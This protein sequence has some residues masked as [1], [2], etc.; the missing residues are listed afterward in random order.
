MVQRSIPKGMKYPITQLN[1]I[2]QKNSFSCGKESL[3][4]YIQKQASQDVAKGLSVCYIL[5]DEFNLIIGYYTLSTLS[6][7]RE[8]I[9]EDIK[10]KIPGSYNAPAILIGRLA[11]N[12]SHHRQGIG[13]L[14][15]FDA[16]KRSFESS[17]KIGSMAVAVDPIDEEA[18]KFYARYGFILLPKSGKMFLSM[19][20]IYK[21]LSQAGYIES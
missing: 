15:L 19:K 11:V 9:P 13:E 6:I 17:L 12:K 4:H 2:H 7:S 1:S 16:L 18:I 8:E 10:K 3:D 20:S 14:I 21:I 5:P